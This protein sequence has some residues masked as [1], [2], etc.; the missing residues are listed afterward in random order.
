MANYKSHGVERATRNYRRTI[1]E[2]EEEEEDHGEKGKGGGKTRRRQRSV[3]E[4]NEGKPSAKGREKERRGEEGICVSAGRRDLIRA[5]RVSLGIVGKCLLSQE[6]VYKRIGPSTLAGQRFT[7]LFHTELNFCLDLSTSVHRLRA[8]GE[9]PYPSTGRA[10]INRNSSPVCRFS[11]SE[12]KYGT[13]SSGRMIVMMRSMLL[14][15]K[16]KILFNCFAIIGDYNCSA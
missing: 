12:N 14:F 7:P 1:K 8:R 5:C 9:A 11:G 2:E 16:R 13:I 10:L 15:L 4:V 6:M 3:M